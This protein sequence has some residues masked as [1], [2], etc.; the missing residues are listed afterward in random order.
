MNIVALS[1]LH[2]FLPEELPRC[3][4]LL[5][6]GDL[7]PV[8]N[9]GLAF[10]A[11]WLDDIFRKWLHRQPARQIVGVAGNH[12]FVFQHEPGWVPRDLP[13]TYLQD[14]GFVWE[15]LN[16]WGTP[17]QPV[18]GNWAFNG[19]PDELRRQWNL[20]PDD[21]DILVCHGPPLGYGDGV[22]GST[23][24]HHC[25]CPHL[26]ERIQTIAPRLVVF[27]HI[28]KGRGEWQLGPTTLAN[29]T[30]LDERYDPIYP[31]WQITLTG[32]T[33]KRLPQPTEPT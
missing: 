21:T 33:S 11:R 22:Q 20:I 18:F 1:D 31:P 23:G 16:I 10:Q 5:L 9:H 15:G 3:D 14:S 24:L 12:D 8:T 30:Q 19:N 6:A 13:W 26:L 17:W 4:L 29:V 32:Q 27:G 7:T 25:G 28:H 2:G